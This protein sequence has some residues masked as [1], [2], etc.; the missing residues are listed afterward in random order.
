MNETHRAFVVVL[1]LGMVG[2][3]LAGRAL[4]PVVE[5]RELRLWRNGWLVSTAAL[6]LTNSIFL[7]AA[8]IAALSIYVHRA[9]KAPFL[10][11]LVLLLTTPTVGVTIGIPGIINS[12]IQVSPPRIFSI[13]FL[14]PAALNLWRS[15]E[16]MPG[17]A[18]DK[19]FVVFILLVGVLALRHG[20]PTYMLHACLMLIFDITLPYYVFSR[21]IRSAQTLRW[22]MAAVVF[23]CVPFALA[24]M[25]ETLRGWRLYDA[26]ILHWGVTLLQTYLF[27]DGML[28]AAATAVEPIAFG[29]AC[30]V[31]IGCF[32]AIYDRMAKGYLRLACGGII[33]LGLIAG[34]S[35]GPW[36]GAALLVVVLAVV[37]PRGIGMLARISVVGAVLMVPVLMSSY[38]ERVIRLLPFVG[39]VDS[40]NEDY[41]QQLIDATIAI[42]GR[43]PLFGSALYLSEPEMLEMYQGQG[44]I[45]VV[46]SYAAVALEHG[47]TGLV[48]FVLIFA[49]A[50]WGLVRLS[51]ADEGNDVTLVARAMLATMAAILLIIGTVSS[52]SV[53]PF[54]YWTMAGCCVAV[55]RVAEQG[56][57][58]PTSSTSTV[59]MPRPLTVLGRR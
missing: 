40:A 56:L 50:S 44:I 15:R 41:R 4:A 54:L 14:L 57:A 1:G 47:L 10:F 3:Y 39:G 11:F 53:I 33:V 23:A 8:A 22:A 58:N 16:T 29:F 31:G 49:V 35:R 13:A 17:A 2:L 27:R 5:Q 48:S 12:V 30:V 55:A 42:V 7:Y 21:S 59:M 34:L 6:F 24:G 52:V 28:R 46:N 20:S 38:G 32:L 18:T 45:D 25:F 43:N 9:S 26:A 51:Y 19:V 36:L 37:R